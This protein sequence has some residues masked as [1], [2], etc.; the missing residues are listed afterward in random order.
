MRSLWLSDKGHT[1]SFPI[2]IQSTI[3]RAQYAFQGALVYFLWSDLVMLKQESSI[4]VPLSFITTAIPVQAP[5]S[6]CTIR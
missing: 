4:S 1:M 6:N 5:I 2:I 3:P